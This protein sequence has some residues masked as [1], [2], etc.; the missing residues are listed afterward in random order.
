MVAT[1]INDLIGNLIAWFLFLESPAL[2]LEEI[3]WPKREVN[4]LILAPTNDPRDFHTS[5]A[6]DL[7]ER[8]FTEGRPVRSRSQATCRGSALLEPQIALATSSTFTKYDENI[9]NMN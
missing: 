7:M 9:T 5:I 3:G 4:G 1:S 8:R 6:T 2:V